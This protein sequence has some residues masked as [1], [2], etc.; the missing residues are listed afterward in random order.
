MKKVILAL[1]SAIFFGGVSYAQTTA[2]S[3]TVT[4][5]DGTVWKNG[6]WSIN[7]QPGQG[8][9]G[10]SQ[11]NIN[12]SPLSASIYSQT[13]T[14]DGSGALA[15]TVYDSTIVNPT[16]SSWYLTICPNS[17][18][19]C[20]IYQFSTSGATQ[21]ISTPLTAIINSPRFVAKSGMYGYNDGEASL[22]IATG[23]TY[24]NVTSSTQRCYNGTSWANCAGS[25]SGTVT[26]VTG[27]ANQIDVATGTTTPII[28]LDPAL[29]LPTGTTLVAPVL[30][31]PHLA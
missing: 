25:T 31:T 16:G 8:F 29:I 4:D 27:T 20:S 17:S 28:S 26:S 14:L 9:T 3:A 22:S 10:P 1:L 30:G 24:W 19:A 6:T 23:A 13:G 12:G 5:S 15:V 11:Y 7:F 18:V 21:N 2:V